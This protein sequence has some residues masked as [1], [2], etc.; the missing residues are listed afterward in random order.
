[1]S[2][3]PLVSFT[4]LILYSS[5]SPI[6][7]RRPARHQQHRDPA[8]P[9]HPP[10]RAPRPLLR[11]PRPP[12]RVP[13]QARVVMGSKAVMLRRVV[14]ASR[15][16]TLSKAVT[17]NKVVM[18]S[19]AATLSRVATLRAPLTRVGTTKQREVTKHPSVRR[20]SAAYRI[21]AASYGSSQRVE[22]CPWIV[23]LSHLFFFLA[24]SRLVSLL[25]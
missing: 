16:V 7:V 10:L 11:A 19:R 2:S 3:A 13:R 23:S 1:M 15:A 8:R 21:Y 20:A 24:S 17:L 4:K 14:R 18:V 22:G 6:T 9:P 12:L 25:I 5:L